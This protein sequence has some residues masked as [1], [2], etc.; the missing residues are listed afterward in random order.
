M[1][2]Q[3]KIVIPV[4]VISSLSFAI[5]WMGRSDNKTDKRRQ[6]YHRWKDANAD[7]EMDIAGDS[8]R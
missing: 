5:Y 8:E 6:R 2:L 7:R 3:P 4:I 1:K